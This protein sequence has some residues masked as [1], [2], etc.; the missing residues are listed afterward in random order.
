MF[1]FATL[2][3]GLIGTLSFAGESKAKEVGMEKRNW[4]EAKECSL[5]E[6][7]KLKSISDS[8]VVKSLVVRD[9]DA[10]KQLIA[11]IRIIPPN[12]DMMKEFSE[13]TDQIDLV[14]TIQSRQA[15]LHAAHF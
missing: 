1:L 10:I 15:E 6:I 8:S 13:D 3:T 14:C 12:G 7:K 4:F 5:L 11:Q 2:M 9:A